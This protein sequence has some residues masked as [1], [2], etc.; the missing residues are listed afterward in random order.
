M[1]KVVRKEDSG[2]EW[3]TN[4]TDEDIETLPEAQNILSTQ[5]DWENNFYKPL[6]TEGKSEA[7]TK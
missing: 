5:L 4:I 3:N 7:L 6:M 1:R 2:I